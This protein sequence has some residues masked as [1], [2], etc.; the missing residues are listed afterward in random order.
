MKRWMWI[1]LW[2][3][4]GLLIVICGLRFVHHWSER[5]NCE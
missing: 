4:V 2:A 5:Q 3:L 1:C